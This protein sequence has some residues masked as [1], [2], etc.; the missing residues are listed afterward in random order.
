MAVIPPDAGVRMRLQTEASL[1]QS[2]QPVRPIPGDLPDLQPGQAFSARILETL[3]DNAYRA[4]VAG[5]Q[6][7][8]QLP[9]GAEPGDT[10]EL[11]VVDR[12]P[13]SIIARRADTEAASTN[14]GQPYPYAKI[15]NAGRIIGELVLP[16][17][18]TP[19][20]A[21]LNRGQPL[22]PQP[23]VGQGVSAAN[24]APALAKAVT[25]S[26]L[27][28]ESHQAQWVAGQRTL[29]SLRAEPQGQIPARMPA[30]DME[31]TGAAE[32]VKPAPQMT[33]RTS[34]QLAAST[35]SIPEEVRPIV[36]QQLDAVVTQRLAWHG[37]A[38]P[39]QPMDWEIERS[40]VG[41]GASGQLEDEAPRWATT[42]RLTMPHLGSIDATL[43]L[44]GGRLQLQMNTA[45]ASTAE[46]LR[47]QLPGLAQSLEQ[48]GMSLQ[49]AEVRGDA[50]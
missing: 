34:I 20:P 16:E 39:G 28:Y 40:S 46:S 41:E 35:P 50:T 36:Q 21:S 10:L 8:L 45:S 4:L 26:G 32:A 1:V 31:R 3:P 18:E 23:P 44:T 24:L 33:E 12:T 47:N 42:L 17:G 29:D 9:E 5:K 13:K 37:E 7:T 15:S 38:W 43:K 6:L 19:Q 2:L 27:F 14:A 11:V 25:Q 22:V 49:S 30:A 48:A